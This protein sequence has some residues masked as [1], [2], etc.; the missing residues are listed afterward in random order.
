[1]EGKC[2]Q[3]RKYTDENRCFQEEWKNKY[4]FVEHNGKAMCLLCQT[5]ISQF[6]SSNLQRHFASSHAHMDQEVPQGAEHRTLKLK[7]LKK[8]TDVEAQFC[9]RFANQSQTVML[10]SYYVA[11]HIAWAKKP[12]SEG[13]V[14]K[15]CLT[16]VI[17]I[18]SPENENLQKK[19][20]GLQLSR[21]TIERRISNLNSDIKSQLHLQ[22]QQCEY[23]IIT[24]N[25]SF[26]TQD[27]PQ[28]S[29]FVRTVSDDC[30]VREELLDMMSLKDRTHG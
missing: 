5:C 2:K 3:K 27:K 28:L 19:I 29:V 25:E 20:S 1:M 6:K 26:H 12:Y 18:L 24:L 8:Q 17:S 9:T 21:H 23:L 30:V 10:A 15:T 14:V 22:L 7:T 13:E 4:F 16:D 11:W